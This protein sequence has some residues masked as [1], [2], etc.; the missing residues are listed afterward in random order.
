MTKT[1]YAFYLIS[2]TIICAILFVPIFYSQII[3]LMDLQGFIFFIMACLSQAAIF[4]LPAFLLATILH[5]VRLPRVACWSAVGLMALLT[6]F[7]IIDLKS[8]SI[9]R[10][11]INGFVLNMIFGS[12]ATQIFSFGTQLYVVAAIVLLLIISIYSALWFLSSKIKRHMHKATIVGSI[13]AILLFTLGTH[14]TYAYGS[15]VAT[16]SIVK[17]AR[18]IPYLYPLTARKLMMKLGATP[19]QIATIN[20]SSGDVRYPYNPLLTH[21]PDSVP[22]IVMIFIDAWSRRSFTHECMPNIHDYAQH[23]TI[24]ANHRACSN[25]TRSS[26]F[27]TFFSVPDIYWKDF[28]TQHIS[29][30]FINRM[31]ELNYDMR[32]YPSASL[33]NPPFSEVVFFNVPNLR[34]ETEGSNTLERDTQI[35]TDFM[36]DIPQMAQNGRPFFSFLFFDLAHSPELP[37]ELIQQF[38]PSWTYANYPAL[39]NNTDPEPFFNLYRNCCYYIDKLVG[40]ILEQIEQL[41]LANNTIV[42]ISGDHAQE[43]NE[44]KKNFWGHNGNFSQW[45]T[46]VPFIMHTPNATPHVA[47]HRTTHYDIVPTLMSCYLGVDNPVSDYSTG[48]QIDTISNRGWHIVGSELNFA[49]IIEGDTIL[50]KEA[51][52]SVQITDPALNDISN[53]NIDPIKFRQATDKMNHFYVGN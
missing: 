28:Q 29:P 35:A 4:S 3:S 2:T 50:E 30:L 44:N 23:S 31:L 17:S 42:I 16:P 19:K 13:V 38:Q 7:L 21:T 33:N 24:Y 32:F 6:L 12:N 48:I 10:F 47:Q 11:H 8:Y 14:L 25:G 5:K 9:Y 49:F 39:N 41:N 45:Q 22:N 43:F 1:A 15:F 37:E 27:S 36:T 20:A 26:I 51:D 18:L 53:F 40:Q 52:G 46:A 34:T